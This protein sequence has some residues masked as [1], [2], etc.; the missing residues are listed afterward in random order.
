MLQIVAGYSRRRYER[1]RH[2]YAPI[3]PACAPR[4]HNM[5]PRYPRWRCSAS[6]LRLPGRK[7]AISAGHGGGFA[8]L[9]MAHRPRDPTIQRRR[10]SITDQERQS[11]PHALTV[12]ARDAGVS[13]PLNS[14]Q[15]GMDC[16]VSR[17]PIRRAAGLLTCGVMQPRANSRCCGRHALNG[18][19]FA[20]VGR[21]LNLLPESL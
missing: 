4:T 11:G 14:L 2:G 6:L 3:P 12:I 17:P 9:V 8:G 16:R 20:R 15:P 7:P 10:P 21:P 5:K 13:P 18:W 19:D 1:A